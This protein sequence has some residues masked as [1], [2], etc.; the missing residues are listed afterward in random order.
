M[1]DVYN[2]NRAGPKATEMPSFALKTSEYI[3]IQIHSE[4]RGIIDATKHRANLKAPVWLLPAGMDFAAFMLV[5]FGL[6]GSKTE[7]AR[8][9]D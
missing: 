7:E 9:E 3:P 1:V 8:Q 5:W 2:M 6:G 4:Y